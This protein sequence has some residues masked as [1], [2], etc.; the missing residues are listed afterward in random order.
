MSFNL[1]TVLTSFHQSVM[2]VFGPLLDWFDSVPAL[3]PL[4]PYG[5]CLPYVVIGLGLFLLSLLVHVLRRKGRGPRREKTPRSP[6]KSAPRSKSASGSMSAST[7]STRMPVQGRA[8]DIMPDFQAP[9]PST[10]PSPGLSSEPSYGGQGVPVPQVAGIPVPQAGAPAQ[11]QEEGFSVPS[12]AGSGASVPD[13]A[14]SGPIVLTA[15]APGAAFGPSVSP[16]P[17]PA[18]A[19]A[20]AFIPSTAPIPSTVPIP[21]AAPSSSMA[22]AAAPTPT[23]AP[24]P[25]PHR[26]EVPEP[27]RAAASLITPPESEFQR[28]YIEMYIY[29]E[30]TTNFSTLR[31]NVN[32]M[33]SRGASTEPLMPDGS[34]APEEHILACTALA[35]LEDLQTK[36]SRLEPGRLSPHGEELCKI[37][38]YILNRLKGNGNLSEDSAR[39]LLEDTLEKVLGT[40][41]H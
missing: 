5:Y 35:A 23:P 17:P 40:S 11:V 30:L 29:L 3:Q 38:N 39:K 8:I 25:P 14:A 10:E 16:V 20:G 21:P 18:A 33:L 22:P 32:G 2:E 28:I 34:A 13:F 37:Y 1:Q 27:P 12:T 6:S 41:G 9:E 26:H 7:G 24:A 36:E 19:F 15:P 31:A 4:Q